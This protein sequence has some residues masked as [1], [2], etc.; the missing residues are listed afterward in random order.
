MEKMKLPLP[1]LSPKMREI[2]RLSMRNERN[3][4]MRK[5]SATG[6]RIL[7]VYD[8]NAPFP[9]YK[10]DYWISDEWDVPQLDYDF[11]RS[12]FEQYAEL[13]KLTPRVALFAPYNENCNFVNAAEKNR[14]CYMHILSDRSEDCYY[15][16][17]IFASRDCVDCAYIHE[18]ELC[19]ECTDC[20]N[21]Y[22][23]RNCFL[24]DNCS[25]CSFC[26]EMIGCRDCFMCNGLRNQQYCFENKQ[27]SKEEYQQKMSAI[28]LG[29]FKQF[30]E[31]RQKFEAEILKDAKYIR[32]INTENCDGNF[33]INTKNC[34]KCYDVEGSEDCFYVRIGA[35]GL[36]D[37]QHSHAIVDGSEL[38]YGNVS[39]TESYFCHNS[40]GCWISKDSAYCE[41]IHG[42]QD[43]LG[44][45]SLRQKKHCILN[46]QYSPEE[47][48]K[49]KNH[50]IEELGEYWGSPF[51]VNLA[52]FSYLD[53][54]YRDYYS[55]TREEIDYVGWF[56]GEEK[57]QPQNLQ[58]ISPEKL[59]DDVKDAKDEDISKAFDCE[60]SKKA[61][62]IIP[63]ELKIL[64]K[65][66]A[67]LPHQHYEARLMAR[68]KFRK[69]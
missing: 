49:I 42:C 46:K 35:N 40:I 13:K 51:P 67:P 50:I 3:L 10:Y 43:C 23:C 64:K 59:P 20:R 54:A 61:F 62:K 55:L 32:M 48:Q 15:T 9:V 5:C 14:N 17:N 41:F 21:C 25:D 45:I 31:F 27:L 52:T 66:G 38:C 6:E 60:S 63:Q 34:H 26:F 7:S 68:L 69:K 11:N 19:Y 58:L 22:H 56:Y 44:C 39:T 65:I 57:A 29:S 53:S 16:Y 18:C 33:L 1:I 12:F 37:V 36:K 2:M 4:Y 8:E 47:Y 24:S 30:T 28:N